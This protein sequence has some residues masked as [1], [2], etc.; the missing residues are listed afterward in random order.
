MSRSGYVNDQ[1]ERGRLYFTVGVPAA[2][3]STVCNDF[4]KNPPLTHDGRIDR[5]DP[6]AS[7]Y[8][9]SRPR[10]VIA[11]D[12]FRVATLGREYVPS[13]EHLIFSLMDTA[14][15]ALLHRGFDVLIDETSTS[16]PTLMRYL[17]L[18]PNA[19]P[20]FLDTPREECERRAVEAGRP[21]LLPVI[22][23][24]WPRFEKLRANWPAIR[25]ELLEQVEHRLS[26]EV[27][28]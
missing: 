28:V 1:Q 13:S 26:T 27:T 11:G 15:A 6:D 19:S 4:V 20:I 5:G 25:Q 21:Y 16:R 7:E 18:D 8:Y 2:G 9:V 3:K 12:D 14:V 10:V 24:L 22:E 17:R 23:R